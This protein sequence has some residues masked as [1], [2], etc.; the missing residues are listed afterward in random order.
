[1]NAVKV[2][3]AAFIITALTVSSNI[4]AQ[5]TSRSSA[6]TIRLTPAAIPASSAPVP[7]FDS[8]IS[9]K[10]IKIENK[11]I[12]SV[13][14][15]LAMV[16]DSIPMEPK[17]FVTPLPKWFFRP[18][19]YTT[20]HYFPEFKPFEPEISGNPSLE[21]V[22]RA[23][24]S[25][26][27]QQMALQ[28]F[29]IARPDLVP[30]NL[31]LLPE[32]PK[33]YVAEIDPQDHTIEI[34]E[35]KPSNNILDTSPDLK[36]R[37]W[38]RS[39]ASSLQFSQAYISPN[40]YQGGNNN[41]NMQL[42]ISYDV[43]LNPAFHPNLLFESSFRYKLGLNSAPEDS[44]R[45]YSISEDLLQINST[46]G[47]K[48]ARRWYYSMSAMFKTQLLN[49]YR[50]NT[51]NLKSAFLSP[52]E[53]NIG[54]GMTYNYVNKKK[55][56]SFDA[57][58]SPLTY[59]M[60]ICTNMSINHED[61]DISPNRKTSSKIGSSGEFKLHWQLARNI[62]FTSRLFAFSD[63]AQFR[64]D[65]ENT[66]AMDINRFLSTQIYCAVRYDT[67]T[68]RITDEPDWHKL[69]VKEILSFGFSYKFSSI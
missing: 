32:A 61:F 26:L 56:F 54:L 31:S 66:L 64:A 65:W 29:M 9:N 42:N 57:S 22:E 69:Q 48:A 41:L 37:H 44:L 49:S 58:I 38:I 47:Y 15:S 33:Q 14:D 53:L 59:N 35:V 43:K 24:A 17:I 51:N 60:R 5:N 28:R 27:Q 63:Y 16:Y 55:T 25:E 40:W 21:W 1:M 2:L 50:K 13:F 46:L 4:F 68:P 67:E 30:Y 62:R 8:N 36:K 45:N 12:L 18:V 52:G 10:A 23:K 6:D 11:E 20:F 19:C 34:R 7:V 39:F 3:R